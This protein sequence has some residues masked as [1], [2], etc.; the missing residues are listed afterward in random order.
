MAARPPG[1]VSDRHQR[2][3]P[4]DP[5]LAA[6]VLAD[7]LGDA[8]TEPEPGDGSVDGEYL[9]HPRQGC[10]DRRPRRRHQSKG[11]GRRWL[12]LA[13]GIGREGAEEGP[14]GLPAASQRLSATG[15]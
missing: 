14:G 12:A 4:A 7:T 9:Q 10:V 2:D 6:D 3:H 5:A 1:D 11:S 15:R 13:E 8:L